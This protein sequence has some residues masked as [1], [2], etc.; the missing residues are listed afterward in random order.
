MIAAVIADI[1]LIL[2]RDSPAG[3]IQRAI[4]ADSP[5]GNII[6]VDGDVPA[7]RTGYIREEQR[8]RGGTE[9]CPGRRKQTLLALGIFST[10]QRDVID[11][12]TV[13]RCQS[14]ADR[15]VTVQQVD[16]TVFIADFLIV[17]IHITHITDLHLRAV[18]IDGIGIK[19]HIISGSVVVGIHDYTVAIY[20]DRNVQRGIAGNRDRICIGC[21]SGQ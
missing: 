8:D 19:R 13:K 15:P 11:V 1:V 2:I 16:Q 18:Q 20:A 17:A 6:T 4:T 10:N 9:L 5:G 14:D 12:K 7:F 21:N 3:N